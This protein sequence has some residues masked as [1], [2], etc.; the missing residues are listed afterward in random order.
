MSTR[1]TTGTILAHDPEALAATSA[2]LRA[3]IS[4]GACQ[5]ANGAFVAWFDLANSC[6]SYD[7][8][9]ISGYALTYLAGQTSLS[10]RERSAGHRAAEWLSERVRTGNLAARDGWDNNAVYLFDLGMIAAGLLSFGR[11]T[12]VDRYLET[13]RLLVSFLRDETRSTRSISA[14]SRRGPHSERASWSSRGVPH[15]AKL[16]QAFLLA[17]ELEDR[18]DKSVSAR[19]IETVKH[20][21]AADGRMPTEG[22][23]TIMLHPHL[24]AAE[25]LWI[26][27]T[28]A[29][30]E[31]ALGHARM[32]VEW[33][34]THQLEQGGLP[35][36]A[37]N[38][39]QHGR[40]PEQSDVTAQAVR[41]ALALGLR[42]RA[43]DRALTRLIEVAR[44]DERGLAIVYQPDSGAIHLNTWAT[45]FAAQALAMAVVAAA[46]ISWQELV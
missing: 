44:G 10:E 5:G 29:N 39:K 41:L 27:G 19:L 7:Y 24:Y 9:E 6:R 17:E 45:L 37:A 30:D 25:G 42:S 2:G 14:V 28:A 16:V 36:F 21:Q 46:P 38:G 1:P 13:G 12:E 40:A 35:R 33:V 26:W 8:P 32:A 3:W 23:A 15:L 18:A 43:V 4:S 31:D 34:F 22:E 20:L 11:R